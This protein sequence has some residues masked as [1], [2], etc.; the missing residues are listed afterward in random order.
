MR[1]GIFTLKKEKWVRYHQPTLQKERSLF[2]FCSWHPIRKH[3]YGAIGLLGIV[4][5]QMN[6]EVMLPFHTLV[7]HELHR[8]ICALP[9]LEYHRTDGRS[10][11]STPL[12]DF[13][14]RLLFEAEW[15]I[16]NIR[17][18]KSHLDRLV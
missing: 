16:P 9:G 14:I 10:R 12:H 8:E 6:S 5:G 4:A 3:C 2:L 11:W 17:N 13:D 18:L 15:L 1:P 7:H